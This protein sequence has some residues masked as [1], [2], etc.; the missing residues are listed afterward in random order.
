MGKILELYLWGIKMLELLKNA[1]KAAGELANLSTK[2][3][4]KILDLWGKAL[5]TNREEIIQANKKDLEYGE[6]IGL[7]PGLMDRLRLD[8]ER[9]QGMIQGLN[10]VRALKDPIGSVDKMIETEDGLR[11]GKMHV[12]IGVIGIIY[13]AR[14]NVTVDCAAL[15]F[16]SGNAL[17]LRGGKEAIHSNKK[18]VEIL[19]KTLTQEDLN[20]NFVQ[21]I[22]DPTRESS[23][24]LMEAVGYVD[25]LIPRGSA[26][27]IHACIDQA[28]VPVLQTGEG[29][30]HVYIDASADL[31]MAW[32]IVE[33]AKTQ[34]IGVCNAVESILVH[35][36]LAKKF[37]QGF[38]KIQE[39]HGIKVHGD[40]G[41]CEVLSAE[42]AEE[43]DWGKE[44]LAMECSIKI[45]ESLDEAIT[46]INQYSTGHSEVI[47]T[48][49]YKNS[50]EFL[51]RVDSACV[52]VN[53]SSRFTDGGQ[54]GMGA[55][56]GISTQKIHA[57]GP[58][59]LEELTS[60]KYIIYGNGQVRK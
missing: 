25:L 3:K 15:T 57:R 16:K 2:E 49:S 30:C 34:R 10:V 42:R 1:K 14:P 27:L 37:L 12:P 36:N 22:D 44:Y 48:E 38:Q 33:N 54:F 7:N 58:V 8:E 40:Q 26:S 43:E 29:N 23:K 20:K 46:H 53:A 11:I 55:E 39:K 5:W 47:V 45:V 35:K 50:Q 9:I 6:E 4:D 18:L 56:M 31:E 41:T 52:Y 24:K 17:I 28:K 19:Q 51:K 13:E 21:F 32:N 60:Y 59:G